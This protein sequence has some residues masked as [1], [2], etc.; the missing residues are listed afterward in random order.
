MNKAKKPKQ[1][2]QLRVG[3]LI[4]DVD[5]GSSG[6]WICTKSGIPNDHY[7]NHDL[8]RWLVERF[9]YWT[10]WWNSHATWE[11][12]TIDY[13]LFQAYGRSLAVDLKRVLGKKQRV[14]FWFHCVPEAAK[15]F[16]V[17]EEIVLPDD[18]K[19]RAAIPGD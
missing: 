13:S 6:I 9:K 7:S 11:G 10:G 15:A 17:F 19:V 5:W 2:P 1:T 14:F 12:E 16:E 8:P 4:V 3:D 18:K